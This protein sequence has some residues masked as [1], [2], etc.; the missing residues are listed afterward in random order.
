MKLIAVGLALSAGTAAVLAAQTG[1]APDSGGGA[2]HGYHNKLIALPYIGYTPQTRLLFGVGGRYQ[3]KSAA[4]RVDSSTRS[5]AFLGNALYTTRGQW[6][7][8]VGTSLYLPRNRWWIAGGVGAGF[9]P[10][11]YYGVGQDTR[12]SNNTN[13]EQHYRVTF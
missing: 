8:S 9:F 7:V 1:V 13:L 12:E 4:A 6:G 3:F 10:V 5:S 2:D 11:T